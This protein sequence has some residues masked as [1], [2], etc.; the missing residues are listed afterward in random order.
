M[1]PCSQTQSTTDLEAIAKVVWPSGQDSH[2][3]LFADEANV[4]KGHIVHL[5]DLSSEKL[6]LPQACGADVPRSHA[7]P[8]GQTW[9]ALLPETLAKKPASQ[10]AQAVA[11][12]NSAVIPAGHS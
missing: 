6:P 5:D 1:Y 9:Q 3:L 2:S 11:L 7:K 4:L 10:V 8:P 12:A